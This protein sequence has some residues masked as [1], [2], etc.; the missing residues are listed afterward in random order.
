MTSAVVAAYAAAAAAYMCRAPLSYLHR[1]YCIVKKF[2]S[3]AIALNELLL[4]VFIVL[5][6]IMKSFM[7]HFSQ[8][9]VCSKYIH[10]HYAYFN[11]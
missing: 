2:S 9:K 1:T 10:V 3:S 6:M 8:L 4:L 5:T 7:F 11:V